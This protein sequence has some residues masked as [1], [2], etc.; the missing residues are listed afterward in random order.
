MDKRRK[1]SRE[2]KLAA[3][4][5]VME[6]GLSY[7]VVARDLGVGDNLIRNW[8]KSFEED[9]TLADGV[10]GNQ[11]V[12][13]ELKRLREENRQLKMERDILKKATAFFAKE[14]N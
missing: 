6:Q 12:E 13:A 4:K 2:F 11:S 5:K 14:S 3:V 1:F 9:G 10:A 8:K 7:T